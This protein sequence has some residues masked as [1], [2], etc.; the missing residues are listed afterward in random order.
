M[1]L[2][3]GYISMKLNL[4]M[5]SDLYYINYFLPDCNYPQSFQTPHWVVG[6]NGNHASFKRYQGE[7]VID[8][9]VE[10]MNSTISQ[11]SN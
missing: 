5:A 9:V 2:H 11:T 8:S 7:K 6:L 10:N 3:L 4:K 1:K